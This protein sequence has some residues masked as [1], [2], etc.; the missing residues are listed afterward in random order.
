[1]PRE[2]ALPAFTGTLDG[3]CGDRCEHRT[4]RWVSSGLAFGDPDA[5]AGAAASRAGPVM[6]RRF[7]GQAAERVVFA[8]GEA[9]ASV[10]AG[11]GSPVGWAACCSKA[12]CA[13]LNSVF[14]SQAAHLGHGRF[15]DYFGQAFDGDVAAVTQPLLQ[16][17][18][19]PDEQAVAEPAD[20]LDRSACCVSGGPCADAAIPCS[21]STA[22]DGYAS[23]RDRNRAGP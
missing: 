7:S 9:W 1:M 5:T 13:V 15:L 20:E 21:T 14:R 22:P 2:V 19:R 17:V 10:D 12:V 8:L 16:T 11:N 6:A 23:F 18:Q 4:R 3:L